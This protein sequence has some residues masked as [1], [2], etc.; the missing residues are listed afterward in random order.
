MVIPARYGATRL[1]GK[2]LAEIDG[3]PM[4]WYVWSKA[5]AAKIPSRVVVATD[6]LRIASAVRGFGGEAVL[7]SPE[8]A[9]GTDRVAE[10]A[11]GMDEEVLQVGELGEQD[12]LPVGVPA[13][14]VARQGQVLGAPRRVE[15]GGRD[16][17]GRRQTGRE[18]GWQCRRA[19]LC[20]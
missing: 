12:P 6:D 4:I 8:C 16:G 10:A 19:R 18:T 2:P 15:T 1:P 11:R 9:S 17:G 14:L 5:R 7:T 13:R 20:R 3:R